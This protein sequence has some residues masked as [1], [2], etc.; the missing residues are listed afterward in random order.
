MGIEEKA[1]D[2]AK[3]HQP[4]SSQLNVHKDHFV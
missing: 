4:F 2:K 3:K 1:L